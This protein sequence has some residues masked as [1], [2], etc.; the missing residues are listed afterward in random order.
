MPRIVFVLVDTRVEDTVDKPHLFSLVLNERRRILDL[1]DSHGRRQIQLESQRRWT[2]A[3]DGEGT[4]KTEKHHRE[5]TDN[6]PK[7]CEALLTS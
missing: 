2:R 6:G 3:N 1:M 7:E 5:T 4:Q